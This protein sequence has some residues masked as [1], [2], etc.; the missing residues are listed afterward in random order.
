MNHVNC[1]AAGIEEQILNGDNIEIN[2]SDISGDIIE[3]N[4]SDISGGICGKSVRT[5]DY[6]DGYFN[7]RGLKVFPRLLT[8]NS[9][10]QASKH[11]YR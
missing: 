6:T 4:Y 5:A 10:R 11:L 3:I 2:Y 8:A 1:A 7:G 9:L